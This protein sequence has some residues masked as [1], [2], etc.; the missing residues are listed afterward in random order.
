MLVPGYTLE[1]TLHRGTYTVAH[2]IAGPGGTR[3]LRTPRDPARRSDVAKL[4]HEHQIL[5]ALGGDPALAFVEASG[6]IEAHVV[7]A[8]PGGD[9]LRGLIRGPMPVASVLWIAAGLTDAL[10]ALHRLRIIHK[11]VNP[12]TILVD[13]ARHR[14]SLVS[15]AL[16]SRLPR[17]THRILSPAS[18]EGSLAYVSPEQTGRMNRAIDYRTDFYS[19]G[20]TLYEMLT[21]HPPFV[22]TDAAEL[23]HAHIARMP[24]PPH[25]VNPAVPRALSALVMKLL[26]KNAEDRYQ[27]AHGIKADVEACVTFFTTGEHAAAVSLGSLDIPDILHVPQKLYGRAPEVE[28]L[29]QAF[30]RASAGR[31]ELVLISG[32]SGIGKSA[33]VNEIH[34]PIVRTQGFFISG[35]YEQY[36]RDIPYFALTRAFQA[37]LRQLLTGSQASVAGWRGRLVAALG[38]HGRLITDVIPEV[39]I[40]I[41]EQPPVVEMGPA[42][43]QARFREVF[44]RFVEVFAQAE[45]PLVLFLDD[46]QW[47]DSASLKLI[48]ALVEGEAARCLL[49]VGAY[50][51][52]E[53]GPTHPLVAA[54]DDV[55]KSG[56]RLSTI[57]LS[58][59]GDEH[60]T[61]LVADTLRCDAGTAAPLSRLL[62]EKTGG[63][64]FFLLQFFQSLHEEKFLRFDLPT[65]RWQWSAADIRMMAGTENIVDLMAGKLARLPPRTR[66]VLELAAC[67]GNQFDLQTL[68]VVMERPR[69]RAAADLW[70]AVREGLVLPL[71]EDLDAVSRTLVESTQDDAGPE[72]AAAGLDVSYRF[73]HDR[74]QQAAYSR[75]PEEERKAIHYKV[76]HLLLEDTPPDG[77]ADRVFD[78]VHHLNL[79]PE[80][81]VSPAQRTEAARLNLLAA[82]RAKDSMAYDTAR[83]HTLAGTALLAESAWETDYALALALTTRQSECE[84]LLGNFAEAERLFDVLLSRSRTVLE[85]VKIHTLKTVLHRHNIRYDDAIKVALAGLK[86]VDIDVPALTD[87]PAL[88]AKMEAEQR[89]LAGHL[90]GRVIAELIDLPAMGDPLMLATMSLLEEVSM[91]A[92]FFTPILVS[93]VTLRMVSLSLQHGNARSSAA[94]YATHGMIIG[95]AA[96]DYVSGHAFGRLAVDLSQK[97]KDLSAQCKAL[98]WFG[99]FINHFRAPITDSLTLLKEA[100]EVGVRSGDPVWVAYAALFYQVQSWAHGDHLDEIFVDPMWSLVTEFQS[101]R[102]VTAY[103]QA[104]RSLKGQTL[105]PGGFDDDTGFS[106]EEHVATIKREGLWLSYQHYFTAKLEAL[107]YFERHADALAVVAEARAAGDIDTI[108]FAQYTPT[109]F[110]F[111]AALLAAAVHDADPAEARAARVEAVGKAVERFAVWAENSPINYRHKHLLLLAEAARLGGRE[112]E[113]LDLY[114]RAIDAAQSAGFVNHHALAAELCGRFHLGRG[115]RAIAGH[116]LQTARASYLRWGAAGK[117]RALDEKYAGLG[118]RALAGDG[119]GGAD[120]GAAIDLVTVMKAS[121]AISGEIV[122]EKLLANMMR[123]MIENAGAQRGYLILERAGQLCIEAAGSAEGAIT[124]L[125]ST[126]VDEQGELSTAVVNYVVHTGQQVVVDDATFDARFAADPYVVRARPKSILASPIVSKKKRVGILYLENN[127]ATSAFNAARLRVLELLSAQAAI[128][129]ENAQLYETMEQRVQ[130]RTRELIETRHQL[131]A[132][133]KLA[134]LGTLAAGIAHEI[135]NPLNFVNNFAQLSSE[136]CKELAEE[137]EGLRGRLG[138]AEVENLTGILADLQGNSVKINQH[139]QRADGIVQAMLEHSREGGSAEWVDLNKL[140]A[141]H[142]SLSL[143]TMRARDP[144]HAPELQVRTDASLDGACVAPRDIGRVITNL[145][146][147]AWDAT[148][149]KGLTRSGGY[150][151]VIEVSTRNLGGSVE[152]HVRDNGTGIA[153]EVRARIFTPFFTTKPGTEGMGLS[154]SISHDIVAQRSGGSLRF[155]SVPGE[156]AEFVVV[157]PRHASQPAEAP[158]EAR[159]VSSRRG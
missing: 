145:L 140:V 131:V 57:S 120:A 119:D 107:F 52:N 157:L 83:R 94:A 18:T 29:L 35:K 13:E 66:A 122:L 25:E 128:S 136:L 85:K 111:Y 40:I 75:I 84:Y 30:D 22:S 98:L 113:A 3:I 103:R 68:S 2:R 80:L 63:N 99:N 117:V 93:I 106:D 151:P 64:P 71:V 43:A 141:E 7:S 143:Q 65:Q 109:E 73:L 5:A 102:A 95:A 123:I 139:G 148:R 142:V 127:L 51:D 133:E 77:L 100:C 72:D 47:A 121:Q 137:I 69:A 138:A 9:P 32:Y 129:L 152:I 132:T 38:P 146:N 87:V 155:E 153:D 11:D 54:L 108:L 149:R 21:G 116:Y 62:L 15:F 81:L 86:L 26:A 76:G 134:S 8:D 58:P 126:T 101:L 24:T 91:L 115:R 28:L 4:H 12:D 16:A 97:H 53:V 10:S 34:K 156:H 125:Q 20:I 39:E 110:L 27:S 124:A 48:R 45:H 61:A 159:P 49:L 144:S 44:Q 6:A 60:V 90:E 36:K 96:G 78:I 14:V 114:D 70:G 55:R 154:L 88:V 46:L 42:E 23:V 67:V 105:V 89:A 41:G 82:E 147:N 31:P 79:C 158:A 118:L 59:L 112:I 150:A 56:A 1:K 130:E 74:V 92:M 17:E 50:R 19:L 135:K 104:A 33:V 37:L